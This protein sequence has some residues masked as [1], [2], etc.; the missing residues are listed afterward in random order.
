[1]P[2]APSQITEFPLPIAESYPNGIA[3]G[4]EGNLWFTEPGTARIGR[5]TPSGQVTEFPLP[6]SSGEPMAITAGP[7]ANLWFTEPNR[8]TLGRITPAGQV[9]EFPLPAGEEPQQITDGGDGDLWFTETRDDQGA[10]EPEE[11][12]AGERGDKIGQIT[13]SGVL[14]E[15]QLPE[16]RPLEYARPSSITDGPDGNLWFVASAAKK[17]GRITPS[18]QTTYF[19]VRQEPYGITAGPGGDLW[20]TE[21]FANCSSESK[22]EGS[23]IG[24]I[25][26]S[27]KVTEFP[28]PS[29][30]SD[31]F[32]ITAGPDGNLWFFGSDGPGCKGWRPGT[33]PGAS[34][35]GSISPIGM[36]HVTE[37]VTESLPRGPRAAQFRGAITAGPD[38]NL[39]FTEPWTDRIGRITPAPGRLTVAVTSHRVGSRRGWVKLRLTCV[40]G[41]TEGPCSDTLNVSIGGPDQGSKKIVLEDRL[42]TIPSELHQLVTLHLTHGTLSILNRHPQLRMVATV[43]AVGSEEGRGDETFLPRS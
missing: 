27:G 19:S 24:R 8:D 15:F 22:L 1:M 34:E 20:F 7:D 23:K 37:F 30:E 17:I 29:L 18:G 26:I 9:E 6:D 12:T 35:I 32:A 42:Y 10:R 13:P 40:G 28:L 14:T 31:P 21:L 3:A 25:T 33:G 36:H 11:P 5:I 41:G 16:P 2:S 38:G 39:W 43:T 4:P